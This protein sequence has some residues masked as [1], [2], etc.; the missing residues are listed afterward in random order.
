M[1]H[2]TTTGSLQK[3][4][5]DLKEYQTGDHPMVGRLHK[6]HKPRWTF[7]GPERPQLVVSTPWA[8]SGKSGPMRQYT[9]ARLSQDLDGREII[10]IFQISVT[11]A[12]KSLSFNRSDIEMMAAKLIEWNIDNL[13]TV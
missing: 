12:G 1:E 3:P 6:V 7:G 13:Q 4:G 5:K 2:K 8:P 11:E 10:P 9:P